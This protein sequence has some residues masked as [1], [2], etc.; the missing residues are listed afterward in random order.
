MAAVASF[1]LAG[2]L[3]KSS[4]P[5]RRFTT[6]LLQSLIRP[7]N[8][9]AVGVNAEFVFPSF[10]STSSLSLFPQLP[11]ASFFVCPFMRRLE[12]PYPSFT[13]V[14]SLLEGDVLRAPTYHDWYHANTTSPSCRECQDRLMKTVDYRY[15]EEPVFEEPPSMT[16][17]PQRVGDD[18]LDCDVSML[19]LNSSVRREVAVNVRRGDSAKVPVI[20][21][22]VVLAFKRSYR[23]LRSR[24]PAHGDH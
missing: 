13:L 15:T 19:D 6:C 21:Q 12:P 17:H 8:E 16:L 22:T 3:A 1:E 20:I 5:V 24:N 2:S 9:Q 10:H 14:M 11:C 7:Y 4:G 23:A 18:I